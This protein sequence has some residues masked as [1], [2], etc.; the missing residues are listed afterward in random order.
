MA[1]QPE[2]LQCKTV[3]SSAVRIAPAGMRSWRATGADGILADRP[4]A[5]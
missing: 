5:R 3:F 1:R 2:H 4:V